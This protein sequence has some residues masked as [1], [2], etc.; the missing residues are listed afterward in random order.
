MSVAQTLDIE[1]YRLLDE[2]L[3]MNQN[4]RQFQV[5]I[6]GSNVNYRTEN[7]TSGD[8]QTQLT[9]NLTPNSPNNVIDR[10][11]LFKARATVK[12]KLI[13]KPPATIVADNIR[14]LINGQASVRGFNN[15][16][17]STTLSINGQSISE[18][19][20]YVHDIF[21]RFTDELDSLVKFKSLTPS[22]MNADVTTNYAQYANASNFNSLGS[23]DSS[24][25]RSLGR[26]FYPYVSISNP[27]AT[28]G[29]TTELVAEVILD[30]N[31]L[32]HL[33]PAEYQGNQVAGLCNVTSLQLNFNLAS[34]KSRFWSMA[35]FETCISQVSVTFSGAEIQFCE[36]T[37][38]VFYS[39]PPTV[40]TSYYELV[41]QT[42][43][44]RTIGAYTGGVDYTKVTLTSNTYQLNQVPSRIIIYAKP[45]E[46]SEQ[47]DA[48]T[49]T[50]SYGVISKLNIQYNNMSSIINSASQ[51]QLFMISSINGSN[52]SWAE[53]AGK[54]SQ[55]TTT[56]T[57]GSY[58]PTTG[59]IVCLEFGKDISS[60]PTAIAGTSVNANLQIQATVGNQRDVATDFE[61]VIL[62]VYSGVL[63]I[64]PGAS[65]K[66]T[67]I[68]TRDETLSLPLL[69]GPSVGSDHLKGGMTCPRE[70]SSGLK[71]GRDVLK[72]YKEGK[73]QRAGALASGVFEN[74][75]SSGLSG[76]KSVAKASL[77]ERFA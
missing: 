45:V 38:P 17:E 12:V 10:T 9:F 16:V 34:D 7:A 2:R 60:D 8:A 4:T 43:Q 37:P 35:K 77:R 15:I 46:Q 6:G 48:A 3:S 62:Y 14:P 53:F 23:W 58:I 68:L 47:N 5:K 39:I 22:L 65:F 50:D 24:T 52:Q 27:A 51:E 75:T 25:R 11:L 36:I 74:G 71:M 19:T 67:S 30:I 29:A 44:K 40:S 72:A 32:I 13:P 1:A 33:S 66:Y 18:E 64:S 20:K 21:N 26:G 59:S 76:G 73:G 28:G 42:S 54:V 57:G 56:E 41:R 61:L 70:I 31:E 55:F 49:Q 63:V 69:E